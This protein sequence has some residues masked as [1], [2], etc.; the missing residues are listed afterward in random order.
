MERIWSTSIEFRVSR[1]T[2]RQPKERGAG[3]INIEGSAKNDDLLEVH[4]WGRKKKKETGKWFAVYYYFLGRSIQ[5][6]VSCNRRIF[7]DV[8]VYNFSDKHTT[9]LIE[10]LAVYTNKIIQK[11]KKTDEVE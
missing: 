8:I 4:F 7:A 11:F 9:N 10:A 5:F 3:I 6:S 1:K 2:I